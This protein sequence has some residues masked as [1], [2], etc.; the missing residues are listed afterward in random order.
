MKNPQSLRGHA[1]RADTGPVPAR[2]SARRKRGAGPA[3]PYRPSSGGGSVF[4][5]RGGDGLPS[6]ATRPPGR[7]PIPGEQA[8]A[9]TGVAMSPPPPHLSHWTLSALAEGTGTVR[10]TIH[11]IPGGTGW[12]R[13]DPGHPG[14]RGIPVAGGRHTT[15]WDCTSIPPNVPSCCRWTKNGGSRRCRAHRGHCRRGRASTDPHTRLQAKRH[16]LPDGGA[17][18]RHR[19]GGRRDGPKAPFAGTVSFPAHVAEGIDPTA[20]VHVIPG[21][22]SSPGGPGSASGWKGIPDGPSTSRRPPPPGRTRWR[23]FSPD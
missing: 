22:I 16:R 14:C 23:A 7:A 11:S 19:Q 13:P 9:P 2:A 15:Q 10:P 18:R 8:K 1:W 20:D 4:P 21:N 5:P 6:N 12:H 17:W 3:G